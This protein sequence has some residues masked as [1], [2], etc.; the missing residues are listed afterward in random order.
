MEKTDAVT[1]EYCRKCQELTKCEILTTKA[2]LKTEI[3]TLASGFR[4]EFAAYRRTLA[5]A[6]GV[7]GLILGALE[8]AIQLIPYLVHLYG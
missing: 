2:E 7:T 3:E 4:A 8:V 5:V 6:A 1:M